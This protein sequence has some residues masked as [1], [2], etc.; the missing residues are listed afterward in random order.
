[1][2]L[3]HGDLSQAQTEFATAIHL[4]PRFAWAHYNLG[5]VF[6]A[7]KTPSKAEEEFRRA[8]EDDPHLEAA[9]EALKSVTSEE[10]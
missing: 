7:E 3:R 1:M 9:R 10:Q 4:Q 6:R 5:L 8:V 2:Y